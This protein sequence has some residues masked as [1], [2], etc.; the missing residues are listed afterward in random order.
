KA[1]GCG[2][3]LPAREV[4]GVLDFR[5][6]GDSVSERARSHEPDRRRGI[7]EEPDLPFQF[8]RRDA[9]FRELAPVGGGQARHAVM[10]AAVAG[11]AG[12]TRDASS[13][14]LRPSANAFQTQSAAMGRNAHANATRVMPASITSLSAMAPTASPLR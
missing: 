6:P 1:A 5:D 4:S 7:P 2:R 9:A 10:I 12:S 14:C 3:R 11:G 8:V 13:R